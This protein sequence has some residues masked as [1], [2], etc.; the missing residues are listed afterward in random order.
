VRA[1][2]DAEGEMLYR[3]RVV[4]TPSPVWGRGE[5]VDARDLKTVFLHVRRPAADRQIAHGNSVLSRERVRV[6]PT[7]VRALGAIQE[8]PDLGR[9]RICSRAKVYAV[10]RDQSGKIQR[11]RGERVDAADFIGVPAGKP[12]E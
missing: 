11:G 3:S 7:I 10:A 1:P 2:D 6:L 4:Y 5:T 12:A 9:Q 8:P